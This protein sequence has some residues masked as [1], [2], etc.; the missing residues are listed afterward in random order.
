M[1][2]FDLS[3][4][5]D[6]GIG[7]EEFKKVVGDKKPLLFDCYYPRR[8]AEP[9]GWYSPKV[10]AMC[11][12]LNSHEISTGQILHTHNVAAES[13]ID[14][15]LYA[16]RVPTW[17][18][19]AELF[20]ALLDTEPPSNFRFADI[21]WPAPALLFMLPIEPCR[22][23]F[24]RNITSLAIGRA[25]IGDTVLLPKVPGLPKCH[26][27]TIA[28]RNTDRDVLF[29][30]KADAFWLDGT[31][32][33][34]Y[35]HRV[36]FDD[37]TT[38]AELEPDQNMVYDTEAHKEPDDL[39][40]ITRLSY[41]AMQLLLILGMEQ[42]DMQT[43]GEMV[44]PGLTKGK[45]ETKEVIRPALFRP[46]W[47]G[48]HYRRPKAPPQGGHHASP[49]LHLRCGHWRQQRWGPALTMVKAVWIEPT[50]VNAAA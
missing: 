50:W 43:G 9:K 32:D 3:F 23:V 31:P 1:K 15:L 24:K 44:L 12:A 47:V 29:H 41:L 49:V 2:K 38:L 4:L 42:A 34:G 14:A 7:A 27:I 22:R 18:V 17:F 36:P 45:K 28:R 33:G 37:K 19:G 30:M 46:R 35:S 40:Q 20:E 21:K 8:Y 16:S 11:A 39:L 13:V 6:M 10:Y 48:E 25:A 26:E 5:R